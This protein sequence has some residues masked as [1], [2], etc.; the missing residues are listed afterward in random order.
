MSFGNANVG[1]PNDTSG[2]TSSVQ[3]QA[4]AVSVCIQDSVYWPIHAPLILF[5][6]FTLAA[7]CVVIV[8]TIWKETLR[9]VSNMFLFS[10]AVSD[11][12]F[13]VIGI[14]LIIACTIKQ[15]ILDCVMSTLL[16]RFTAISS[17]FHLF[18]IA[19][20]RYTIILFSMKYPSFA[21]KPRATGVIVCIWLLAFVSSSI[22][23]TWYKWNSEIVEL[24]EET[25]RIDKVY[26]L[27][28]ITAFLFMPLLSMLYM[29]SHV[30]AIS[31]RH[32]FAIRRRQKN[33]D[34][35][36][37]SVVH[38]LRG[39]FILVTMMII[40]I[41]CWL[42]FFLLMLQDHISEKF[43]YPIPEW[44]W[45]LILYL[46]FV[47]PLANPILCAFCKQDYRRAWKSFTRQ[48]RWP[49]SVRFYSIPSV[50]NSGTRE[51]TLTAGTLSERTNNGRNSVSS[52]NVISMEVC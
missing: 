25:I 4:G 19:C 49:T 38:D 39:T 52:L 24:K 18:V 14:P 5:L 51:R 15:A 47:P 41:S 34:Q 11:L 28:L 16:V 9:T 36:V 33:L 13:G 35:P 37:A 10:L 17:V 32:I 30:L 20:D 29:Y 48:Q 44:G 21:T 23:F 22:Q 8:L 7:N 46:R 1:R 3:Q 43:M 26:F 45:C 12:L 50:S 2:N 27:I 40:F 6:L 42:P 31:L